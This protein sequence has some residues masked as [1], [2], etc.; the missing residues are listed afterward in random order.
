MTRLN[1]TTANTPF[2]TKR[3]S[4][5]SGRAHEPR[6]TDRPTRRRTVTGNAWT[7]GSQ[8]APATMRIGAKNMIKMCS[9]M[10]TKK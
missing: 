10:W 1:S 8:G 6:R 5:R 2:V 9:I 3:P 7:S 4:A